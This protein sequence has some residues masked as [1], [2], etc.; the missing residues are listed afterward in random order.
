MGRG[1][2]HDGFFRF[3]SRGELTGPVPARP[4]EL[5][6]IGSIGGIDL[7]ARD[8]VEAALRIGRAFFGAVRYADLRDMP[9]DEYLELIEE[10]NR[11]GK[12]DKDAT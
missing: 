10:V 4:R 12:E 9:V 6:L 7:E 5:W 2:G 3:R 8:I 11:Q 1:G